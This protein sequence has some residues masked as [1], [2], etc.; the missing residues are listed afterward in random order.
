MKKEKTIERFKKIADFLTSENML[1]I[2]FGIWAAWSL[3]NALND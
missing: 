3:L 1:C 2:Y